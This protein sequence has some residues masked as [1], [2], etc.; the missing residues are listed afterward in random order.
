[1]TDVVTFSVRFRSRSVSER[2]PRVSARPGGPQQR[3]QVRRGDRARVGRGH[4]RR[5]RLRGLVDRVL[6]EPVVGQGAR[7]VQLLLERDQ[8]VERAAGAGR[9]FAERGA[10]EGGGEK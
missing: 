1:M 2:G 8:A 7:G 3:A 5:D 9:A 10:R 6:G 4:G